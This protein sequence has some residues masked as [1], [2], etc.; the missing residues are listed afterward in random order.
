MAKIERITIT[1]LSSPIST[2]IGFCSIFYTI[3][4]LMIAD[5]AIHKIERGKLSL[6]FPTKTKFSRKYFYSRPR[7]PEYMAELTVLVQ[8]E[9]EKMLLIEGID[10]IVEDGSGFIHE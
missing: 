1:L 3:P 2:L 7:T 8:T 6:A 4:P 9:Y 5:I 10:R